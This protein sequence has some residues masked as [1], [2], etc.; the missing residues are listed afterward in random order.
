MTSED[1]LRQKKKMCEQTVVGIIL[2]CG[3]N[4]TSLILPLKKKKKKTEMK[5][6]RNSSDLN[7]IFKS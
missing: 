5:V 1:Y 4:G 2:V 7:S 6:K 3:Q